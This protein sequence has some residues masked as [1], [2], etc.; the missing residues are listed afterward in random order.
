MTLYPFR[1]LTRLKLKFLLLLLIIACLA[2]PLPGAS[3]A[4]KPGTACSKV[5]TMALYKS[6]ILTCKKSGSKNIWFSPG[7]ISQTQISKFISATRPTTFGNLYKYRKGIP[8]AAWSNFNKY[9]SILDNPIEGVEIF[10]GANTKPWYLTPLDAVKK[11]RKSFPKIDFPKHFVFIYYS[12]DDQSWAKDKLVSLVTSN[13]YENFYR[14]EGGR[15]I[16]SNCDNLVKDCQGAK[17]LTAQDGTGFLLIGVPGA[18]DAGDQTATYRLQTGML[19]AHEYFH[20]LQDVP[21]SG[22]NL[23]G[24]DWPPRWAIEGGAEFI[25]NAAINNASFAKYLDFRS[26]DGKELYQQSHIY[27]SRYINDYLTRSNSSDSSFMDYYLGSRVIEILVAL[28]GQTSLLALNEALATRIGFSAAFESVY[29]YPWSKA[30]PV[31]AK[32]IAAGIQEEK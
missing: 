30:I 10:I 28:K 12:F 31:I 9:A 27:T 17:A 24:V 11:V 16:D 18:I 8:V 6:S 2:F 23:E 4:V 26:L 14:N 32:V 21:F 29:G 7:V 19:E 22:K 15:V 13:D 25:Q 5:G 20:T 1:K 3:A